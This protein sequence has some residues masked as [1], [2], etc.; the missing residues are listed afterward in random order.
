MPDIIEAMNT[1]DVLVITA[2][3]GSGKTTRVPPALMPHTAGKILV[4]QPRRAAARLVARRMADEYN[5]PLGRRFGYRI[6]NESKSSAQT[7]VEV[8]TEGVLLRRIQSDPFLEGIDVVILDEFH[9][10]SL[11]AD[12]AVAFLKEIQQ[13]VRTD[14]KL[15]IL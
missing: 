8:V 15:L 4:L 1:H 12:L 11:N 14:L 5:E 13:E 3:P 9:E 6:R 10:R 7:Q 2:P